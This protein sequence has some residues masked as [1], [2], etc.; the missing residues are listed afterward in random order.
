M[1]E[2]DRTI[3]DI[4]PPDTLFSGS[5]EQ[6]KLKRQIISHLVN[7]V[8]VKT[9]LEEMNMSYQE[10]HAMRRSDA[11]FNSLVD[12]A[13]DEVRKMFLPAVEQNIWEQAQQPTPQ[14]AAL[15]F[16]LMKEFKG[17]GEKKQI[18]PETEHDEN[19][20]ADWYEPPVIF[21]AEYREKNEDAES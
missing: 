15:G 2:Q 7:G 11:Y 12:A 9:M 1:S 17:W 18:Q 20:L 6:H 13:F 10:F 21:D 16:R 14:G 19:I 4:V 8:T 5:L 3:V